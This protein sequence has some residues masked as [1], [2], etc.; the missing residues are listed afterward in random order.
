MAGLLFSQNKLK[1]QVKYLGNWQKWPKL[2]ASIR[3]LCI[4]AYN[5]ASYEFSLKY[6]RIVKK[7]VSTGTPPPGAYW[8]PMALSTLQRYS[9]EYPEHK[10]YNLTGFLYKNINIWKYKSYTRVGVQSKRRH[11]KIDGQK[12]T[13][14]MVELCNLLE[15]GGN[16]IP[17]RPLWKPSYRAAGGD[18][19]VKKMVLK[20]LSMKLKA[21]GIPFKI[22]Y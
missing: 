11:P 19:M 2:P 22:R 17:A 20:V 6:L 3:D 14:T 18:P 16:N 13:L 21:A 5:K 8:P 12:S 1:V 7:S 10:L 9:K 15:R 4:E